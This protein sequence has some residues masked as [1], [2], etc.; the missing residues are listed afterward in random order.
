[1]TKQSANT[2][3]STADV[4]AERPF[5]PMELHC[6]TEFLMRYWFTRRMVNHLKVLPLRENPDNRGT[7]VSPLL[8]VMTAL[9]FYE[10]ATFQKETGDLVEI[11]Q[12]T[13]YRTITEVSEAISKSCFHALC[14]Y[15]K[16]PKCV[17]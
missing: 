4:V 10:A 13:V 9:R 11:S 16:P 5:D 1:M 15:R 6:D 3:A 2:T 7:P 17:S 8:R 12:P 14:G